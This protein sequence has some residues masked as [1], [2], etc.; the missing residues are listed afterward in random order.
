MTFCLTDKILSY[1]VNAVRRAFCWSDR[2]R[3]H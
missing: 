2:V 3:I 1:E